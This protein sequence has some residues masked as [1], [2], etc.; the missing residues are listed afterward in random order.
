MIKVKVIGIC[1]GARAGK[2]LCANVLQKGLLNLHK[3][4]SS[5]FNL[6]YPLKKEIPQGTKSKELWRKELIKRGYELKAQN[7][8]EHFAV[9][10]ISRIK[11]E[12]FIFVD[13]VRFF[14]EVTHFSENTEF[15]LIKVDTL[16]EIRLARM[17]NPTEF[18]DYAGSDDGELNWEVM[19]E[20]IYISNNVSIRSYKEDLIQRVLPMI[21]KKRG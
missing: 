7:G 14:E 4:D 13:D 3:K 10:L 17:E 19:E 9:V 2:T 8:K 21:I 1:G 20:D 18:K 15:L 12:I 6:A 5:I 11:E 16:E